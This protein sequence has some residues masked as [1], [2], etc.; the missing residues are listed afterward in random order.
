MQ[1]Q[2]SKIKLYIIKVPI[3]VDVK[4]ALEENCE[5]STSVCN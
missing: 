5:F 1:T 3:S 4:V 2:K